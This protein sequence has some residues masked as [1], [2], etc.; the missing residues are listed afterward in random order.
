M[1]TPYRYQKQKIDF[2]STAPFSRRFGSSALLGNAK[3]PAPI[4]KQP[5]LQRTDSNLENERNTIVDKVKLMFQQREAVTN[6][7]VSRILRNFDDGDGQITKEE[8]ARGIRLY[9]NQDLNPSELDAVFGYFDDDGSGVITVDEIVAK[10]APK[11]VWELL[12]TKAGSEPTEPAEEI[13]T[14]NERMVMQQPTKDAS[15][16]VWPSHRNLALQYGSCAPRLSINRGCYENNVAP[17]FDTMPH[18][19]LSPIDTGHCGGL[20]VTM[21]MH[22]RPHHAAVDFWERLRQEPAVTEKTQGFSLD[23]IYPRPI[24]PRVSSNPKENPALNVRDGSN[25]LRRGYR[26][27]KACGPQ[28]SYSLTT[29]LPGNTFNPAHSTAHF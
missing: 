6:K 22:R 19:A 4:A 23:T 26:R 5:T 21:N 2:A 8:L 29:W 15:G 20:G 24:L 28:E 3:P 7:S 16:F 18:K 9:L 14:A 11:S 17:T 27:K 13:L 1:A 25:S 12:Q 10:L